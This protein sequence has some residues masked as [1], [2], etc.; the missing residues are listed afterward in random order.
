MELGQSGALQESAGAAAQVGGPGQLFERPPL[1]D[2]LRV[3][4]PLARCEETAP[5]SGVFSRKWTGVHASF[6]CGTATGSVN[7]TAPPNA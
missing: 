4:A 1:L 2:T 6:D 3:G 7:A 5:G